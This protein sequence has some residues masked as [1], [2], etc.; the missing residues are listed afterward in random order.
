ME[1]EIIE[2]TIITVKDYAEDFK[3]AIDTTKYNPSF[4][5][6]LDRLCLN[7]IKW[8]IKTEQE[9]KRCY[10][11]KDLIIEIKKIFKAQELLIDEYMSN[12]K[13]K[14]YTIV[15]SGETQRQPKKKRH[16]A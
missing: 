7:K 8:L 6:D 15:R 1:R 12:E 2:Q 4:F 11:K 9:E 5:I 14:N 16:H 13:V 3:T 10:N